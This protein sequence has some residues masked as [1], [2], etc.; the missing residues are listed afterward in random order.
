MLRK[1]LRRA[2][3]FRAALTAAGAAVCVGL[4]ASG[5][6]A[7]EAGDIEVEPIEDEQVEKADPLATDEEMDALFGQPIHA[8][9]FTS[10][11]EATL[12]NA[13]QIVVEECMRDLGFDFTR[14]E[15]N[16]VDPLSLATFGP[17]HNYLGRWYV[18][19]EY[20]AEHGF[21]HTQ[22]LLSQ[23]EEEHTGGEPRD[24]RIKDRGGDYD[25]AAAALDGFPADTAT[26]SGDPVPEW[27]CEGWAQGE[28]DEGVRLI[29]VEQAQAGEV[30]AAMGQNQVATEI[31]NASQ[32]EAA[33][34]QRVLD[35]ESAWREC[36]AE[37]G[38][39]GENPG[40]VGS[41]GAGQVDTADTEAAVRNVECREDSALTQTHQDVLAELQERDVEANRSALDERAEETAAALDLAVEL[42]EE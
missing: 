23:G 28:I 1:P 16:E 22:E 21:S 35:A 3:S 39:P 38:Y 42:T 37:S 9:M 29:G 36:M 27:G 31:F 15:P 8:Y 17:C 11:E 26:P 30:A 32:E 12:Q 40:T 10:M 6:A 25:D 4:V 5:C 18:D 7:T 33:A 24:P 19:A 41:G 14:G 20:A 34:D 13:Q 2:G